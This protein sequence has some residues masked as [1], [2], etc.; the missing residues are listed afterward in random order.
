MAMAVAMAANVNARCRPLANGSSMSLGKNDR[1][2]MY[3]AWLGLR[4]CSAPVGP[5]SSLIGL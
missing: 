4:C 1:P 3:A 2:V 5:S